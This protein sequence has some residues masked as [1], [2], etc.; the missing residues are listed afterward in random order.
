MRKF[1]VFIGLMMLC[2]VSESQVVRV[3]DSES[4]QPVPGVIFQDS[5]ST[6]IL[7]SNYAGTID[8]VP[9]EICDS[10]YISAIGFKSMV[11]SF[12]ELSSIKT[13]I[14]YYES[15]DIEDVVVSASRW[16]QNRREI[17]VRVKTISQ[18]HVRLQNPQTAADLLALSDEVFIQKSQQGGGSPMIR[19]FST[20]RLLYVVDGV[21]MNTAIFRSGNLQNVISLDAFAI[22]RSEV[23]FGPGSVMYGSDA[24]GGVMNFE[25]LSPEFSVNEKV[26]LSGAADSRFSS[27]NNE[28]SQHFHLKIGGRKWAS[29]TSLSSNDYGH[30][31]MGANG[32]DDYLVPYYV[33]RADSSDM[34]F[35]NSDPLLQIPSGFTQKNIMQ[36]IGFKPSENFEI[37]YGFHYS[38]TSDYARFDR[39]I[40]YK[41]GLPRY[42]EWSYGPQKWLMNNLSVSHS[43][44]L[45]YDN[46]SIRLAHQFFEESRISRD[47]NKSKRETR[48]EDVQAYSA[49]VDFVKQIFDSNTLF[50]G[51]EAVQN[52]VTSVGIDENILTSEISDGASR[53]PQSD[54]LSYGAYLTDKH[55]FGESFT[56]LGGVRFSYN[57]MNAVFDTTFYKFPFTTA[58]PQSQQV[59]GSFG[60]VWHPNKKTAFAINAASG[61]RAPNVDDLGK[62]FDS[63]PGTVTVPNP[64][65]KPETAYNFEIS[66]TQVFGKFAKIELAGYYTY[67]ADAMVRRDFTLNGL[68]SMIYDGEM[69]RIQAIQNVAFATV[70]GIQAGLELKLPYGFSFNGHYNYQIGEDELDDGAVSPSRHAAPAFG[71]ARLSYAYRTVNLQVYGVYNAEKSFEEL[72]QEEIDK[73]YLY[74][75]D[76]DGNPYVPMWYTLNFKASA[77]INEHFTVFAGLEN[78]LDKRYRPY[79]SGISAPGRNFVISL[80][81]KI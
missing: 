39:H 10:I 19:G 51:I 16:Q 12:T 80:H 32:P 78:M 3:V 61:Y 28:K 59:T 63:A 18:K 29:V 72:P 77:Q 81:A 43:N 74:A 13:L 22:E 41:N 23:L 1:I 37:Q 68:D 47:L 4:E 11:I 9:F 2:Y 6:I 55:N 21:R 58:N 48:I 17:P 67:L 75:K 71:T 60:F 42:C 56:L 34:I 50:Y 52:D 26:R 38:E 65:L 15:F 40:R 8:I 44:T 5:K 27:A 7:Q 70:Y 30:L 46:L 53:Y 57:E 36:K 31:R 73:D 79:S 66:G 35:T 33:Q 45:I 64:D 24:I 76:A 69:S 20:N 54:W 49:N 25:T 62:V 14:I